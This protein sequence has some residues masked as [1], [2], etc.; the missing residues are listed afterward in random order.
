MPKN[1]LGLLDRFK[2]TKAQ[3]QKLAAIEQLDLS[4]E[5]RNV[6]AHEA[7]KAKHIDLL[8]REFK[9]FLALALLSKREDLVPSRPVDALWH[10]LILD[11]PKYRE[12][13]DKVF[14][15]YLD[16]K[17][18]TSRAK[19]A[20]VFAGEPFAETKA[21]LTEAFGA[22]TETI[23]GEFAFCGPCLLNGLGG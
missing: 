7:C 17:P 8:E 2:A 6:L 22:T 16:H 15:Y 13:C 5:K 1:P 11:T 20:A 18:E 3:L 10:E 23:W 19:G 21:R 4:V 9:R 12:F 14:G